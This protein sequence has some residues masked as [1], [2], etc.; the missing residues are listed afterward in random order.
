MKGSPTLYIEGV[1]VG[2][3]KADREGKS[4]E[5]QERA[6]PVRTS[7]TKR[8]QRVSLLVKRQKG[9]LRTEKRREREMNVHRS[10]IVLYRATG[11]RECTLVWS[12]LG[13]GCMTNRDKDPG[14]FTFV[15][16]ATP[17]ESIT[18]P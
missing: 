3:C 18:D 11:A 15:D 12:G 16:R 1:A 4:P 10:Q 14:R 6:V 13:G 17:K 7:Q 8:V 5:S 9:T 2:G